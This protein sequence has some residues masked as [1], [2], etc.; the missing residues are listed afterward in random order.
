MP[1]FSVRAVLSL[2]RPG[3]VRACRLAR[4]SSRPTSC[5]SKP[6]KCPRPARQEHAADARSL[7]LRDTALLQNTP[8]TSSAFSTSFSAA[9]WQSVHDTPG[10]NIAKTARCA[11]KTPSYTVFEKAQA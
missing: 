10:F 11:A 9:R 6:M 3:L 4:P 2:A 1:C 7:R 5:V 8:N